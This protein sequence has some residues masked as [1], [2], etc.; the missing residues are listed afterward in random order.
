MLQVTYPGVVY[1]GVETADSLRAAIAMLQA[2]VLELEGGNRADRPIAGGAGGGKAR[3]RRGP[4]ASAA[5]RGV[6]SGPKDVLQQSE[7][8][9]GLLAPMQR[10]GKRWFVNQWPR[11]ALT[12]G[13]RTIPRTLDDLKTFLRARG[14]KPHPRGDASMLLWQVRD[15][16]RLAVE[17]APRP[18][19]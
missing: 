16:L 12:S 18:G 1:Q 6:T 17:P 10:A 11:I 13:E 3:R 2:R 15:R 9:G 5:P 14:L 8:E 4:S 19:E 7:Q